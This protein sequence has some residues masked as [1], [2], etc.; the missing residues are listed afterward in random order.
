MT[1]KDT[2]EYI[3]KVKRHDNHSLDAKFKVSQRFPNLIQKVVV[4]LDLQGKKEIV[5]KF[6]EEN[7]ASMYIILAVLTSMFEHV[8]VGILIP[9]KNFPVK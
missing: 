3:L 7:F 8:F 6:A 5:C 4:P 9:V 2:L 1:I